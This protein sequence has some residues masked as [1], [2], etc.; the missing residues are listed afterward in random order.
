MIQN[1]PLPATHEPADAAFWQATLRAEL[2]VQQCTGCGHHRFP[3]RPMCPVCQ[4]TALQWRTMSG[5]G[6]IWSFAVPRPPLLP[7]FEALLPYVTA[8][9]ELEED[10]LLRV[11]GALLDPH[12][13]SMQGVSAESVA[14]GAPVQI[15]FCR[16]AEDV[17]FPCLQLVGAGSKA[18]VLS[19]IA[20]SPSG[21][22][23]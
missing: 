13:G 1:I 21:E 16:C 4:S 6:T 20:A 23:A 22:N 12:T 11:T 19:G 7:A 8:V 3:P 9:V 17:A 5:R 14:I 10:P 18:G 2:V 15:A